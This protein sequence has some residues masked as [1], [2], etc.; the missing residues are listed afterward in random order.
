MQIGKKWRKFVVGFDPHGDMMDDSASASFFKFVELWKPEIRVC[1]GDL[2][3]FRCLR[4]KASEEERRDSMAVDYAAGLQWL[5]SLR[6]THYVRGNHCERLWDLASIDNGIASDYARDLVY[7]TE[8]KLTKMRCQMF[9]YDKRAGVLRIGH[10]KVI[11]GFLCGVTAARRTAL[12]YGSVIM[13]HGHSIQAASIE[14]LEPRTGM[15]CG[16]LCKLDH[17]YNRAQVGSLTHEHGWAYGV[18][19]DTGSYHVWQARKIENK[20]LLPTGIEEL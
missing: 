17:D 16:C 20:W 13:G 3:D 18:V 19:S 2:W 11:H 5:K 14:G 12:T 9:P 1:G 10:L 6:A 15:M 7:Q 4:K 8:E